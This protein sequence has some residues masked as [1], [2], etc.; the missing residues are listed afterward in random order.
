MAVDTPEIEV[1]DTQGP[2]VLL[3]K[4][5]KL[6]VVQQSKDGS[7]VYA[8]MPG[9]LPADGGNWFAGNTDTGVEYV[10]SW[11]SRSYARRIFR[12]RVQEHQEMNEAL[13]F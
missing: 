1:L 10:A 12:A 5:D 4:G 9:D 8:V 3:Q 2:Y 13:A 11:Y 7:Q 6:T